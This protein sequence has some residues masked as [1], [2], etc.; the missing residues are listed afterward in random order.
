[1]ETT[2]SQWFY[3]NSEYILP[4]TQIAS[5]QGGSS[6]SQGNGSQMNLYQ[7]HGDRIS[8]W[9]QLMAPLANIRHYINDEYK[10]KKQASYQKLK[11][12][13][14]P[15]Q[16]YYGLRVTDVFGSE[17]YTQAMKGPYTNPPK[18]KA[19]YDTQKTLLTTW[20]K[21]LNNALS[22]LE[23]N[24]TYNGQTVSEINPQN[25]DFVYN[26]DWSKW[27]KFI[28]SLKLR[29]AV[30][31][32]GQ[33]KQK[34]MSIVQNVM[35]D[36]YGPIMTMDANFNWAPNV[37]NTGPAENYV[38]FPLGAK[39]IIA[40]L[41]NNKDPRLLDMF[42]KNDF[43][44]RVVQG[45]FDAGKS[46]DIPTYIRRM[47]KDTTIKSGTM[48]NG[49]KVQQDSTV[50][51]GWKA[52]GEPW[53]RY[54]GAPV[55]PDSTRSGKEAEEYFHTTNWQL[56]SKQYE[57]VSL[58]NQHMFGTRQTIT[59]PD[60]PSRTVTHQNNSAYFHD[61]LYS[62]AETNL[63]LAEFKLMGANL[64]KSAQQYFQ[65]GIKQSL[66]TYNW[67]AKN[68]KIPYYS[69]AYDTKYGASIEDTYNKEKADG[70]Q[71][72]LQRPAYTLMNGSSKA[73]KLQ[74]VYVQEFINFM[75]SPT[76]LYVTARRSGIPEKNSQYLSRSPF[77]NGG[78]DLVIPRRFEVFAPTKDNINYN[79]A[80]QAYKD[81][82]FT[83]G[84]NNPQVLH[85][86]RVWYDKGAPDWGLGPNY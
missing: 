19:K 45:F 30:R 43:N 81:E 58:Y 37:N 72:L 33:D 11:A 1:M 35:K 78:Q 17:P 65:T 76:Q 70:F 48:Y 46:Q 23:S 52:P 66:E 7:Q 9:Y 8:Q 25:Q 4:W 13:T 77:Y 62:A 63:Y 73:N 44:S 6:T 40:F 12:I 85:D 74:K 82:G 86:Q 2:Y 80:V 49:K 22:I 71:Q 50:F 61:C 84:S 31:L 83:A 39:R 34:A 32:L 69:S 75:R 29:I 18:L 14:Y 24:Q 54:F 27:A 56:Q 42:S 79:N 53:V 51:T 26:G 57:P 67:M 15:V 68:N 16:I 60:V 3:D 64:P 55:A 21:Q 5:G 36:Q 28:N 41:R 20:L 47:V 38:A 59:Y 10:G